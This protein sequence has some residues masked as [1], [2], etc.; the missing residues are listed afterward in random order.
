MPPKKPTGSGSGQPP[1]NA[2][3]TVQAI[4][5]DSSDPFQSEEEQDT[6]VS[7]IERSM[8]ADADEDPEI[9]KTIPKDLLTRI[10][11]EFFIKDATRISKD[12]NSAVGK[13]VDIFVREAI[14]R[15]AA[16][17]KSGFFE[18]SCNHKLHVWEDN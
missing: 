15:V 5:S 2:P 8:N 7:R 9:G 10:L 1:K 11:H 13:Y 14:A 6:E 12:A 16:E 3:K 18:V 17:K 4:E